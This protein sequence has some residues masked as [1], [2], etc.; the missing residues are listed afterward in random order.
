VTGAGL[1][2][3]LVGTAVGALVEGDGLDGRLVGTAVGA[4]V[5]GDDEGLGVTGR[6]VGNRAGLRVLSTGD[7]VGTFVGPFVPTTGL[8]VGRPVRPS[9]GASDGTSDGIRELLGDI[10]IVGATLGG[11]VEGGE[12][13]WG[14]SVGAKLAIHHRGVASLTSPGRFRW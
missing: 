13:D 11:V 5:E 10:V 7:A 2:G 6:G 8:L 14:G 3:R 9:V 1:D 4:L 12:G